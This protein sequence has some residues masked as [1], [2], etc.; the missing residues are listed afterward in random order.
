MNAVTPIRRVL[1]PA[2]IS[3]AGE[4]AGVRF[5]GFFTANIR[6][7]HTRRAYARAVTDFLAWCAD[8]GVRSIGDVQPVHERNGDWFY[9]PEHAGEANL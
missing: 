2:L 9:C 8:A 7:P 4:R 6:N 1:T 3:A 5:V